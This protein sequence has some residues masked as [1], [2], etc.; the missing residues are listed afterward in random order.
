[1]FELER[2]DDQQKKR[3]L[4]ETSSLKDNRVIDTN[5]YETVWP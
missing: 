5:S 1:M 4:G 2:K 3:E